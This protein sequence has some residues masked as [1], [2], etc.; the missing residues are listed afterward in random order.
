MLLTDKLDLLEMSGLFEIAKPWGNP[1]RHCGDGT[2]GQSS[3]RSKNWGSEV[4]ISKDTKHI[5]APRYI[6][7][8][9]LANLTARTCPLCCGERTRGPVYVHRVNTIYTVW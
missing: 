3:D 4:M 9:N 1:P 6:L 8:E 7:V 2:R 5:N